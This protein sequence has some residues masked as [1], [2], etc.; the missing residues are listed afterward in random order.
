MPKLED[1]TPEERAERSARAARSRAATAGA[2]RKAGVPGLKDAV[3]AKCYD[4]AYDPDSGAGP[5]LTQIRACE[6]RM[7]PLWPHRPGAPAVPPD[8]YVPMPPAA[9]LSNIRRRARRSR[10]PADGKR[11]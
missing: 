9:V 1:L 10:A 6:V 5:A 2:R 4:C 7:C 11:R 8:D 3:R